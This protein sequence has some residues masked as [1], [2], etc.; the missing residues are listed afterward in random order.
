MTLYFW[1]VRGSV[2]ASEKDN[3]VNEE[4][5][6]KDSEDKEGKVNGNTTLLFKW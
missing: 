4:E 1:Y 6:V 3:G 5:E 2:D